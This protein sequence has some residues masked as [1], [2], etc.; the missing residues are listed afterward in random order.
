MSHKIRF[1]SWNWT[2][3]LHV[4]FRSDNEDK[5]N[6]PDGDW[7]F[8]TV[9]KTGPGVLNL[10]ENKSNGEAMPVS[11]GVSMATAPYIRVFPG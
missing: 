2:R 7:E 9:R 1:D 6:G 10:V 4:I 3:I 8:G 11:S 5:D